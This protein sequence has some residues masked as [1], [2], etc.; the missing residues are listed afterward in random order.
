MAKD[1]DNVLSEFEALKR[2]TDRVVDGLAV[3]AS[4]LD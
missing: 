2:D 3:I 1:R 4:D